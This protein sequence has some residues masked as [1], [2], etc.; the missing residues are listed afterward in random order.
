MTLLGIS[1]SVCCFR[2]CSRQVACYLSGWPEAFVVRFWLG[3]GGLC[4]VSLQ[5][6]YSECSGFLFDLLG[7]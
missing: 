7:L 6:I 2:L 5:S 1:C 3:G 4:R